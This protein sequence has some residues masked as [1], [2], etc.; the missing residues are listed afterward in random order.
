M[1]RPTNAARAEAQ[2]LQREEAMA[3]VTSFGRP[4]PELTPGENTIPYG[5]TTDEMLRERDVAA[6]VESY[7]TSAAAIL[8]EQARV[9]GKDVATWRK[10]VEADPSVAEQLYMQAAQTRAE[11]V[12]EDHFYY[13]KEREIGEIANIVN[14]MT[15]DQQKRFSQ[16]LVPEDKRNTHMALWDPPM[17]DGKVYGFSLIPNGLVRKKLDSGWGIVPK[18]AVAEAPSLQC[19]MTDDTG[20]QC[21]KK[22]RTEGQ[23][24]RHRV[25][26][27][28]TAYKDREKLDAQ[29][30]ADAREQADAQ[31][32]DRMEQLVEQQA[33]MIAAL[34]QRLGG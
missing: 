28:N 29:R 7:H 12:R 4:I 25:V 26:K 31:R 27:H 16:T 2:R 5:I 17:R 18:G 13:G 15:V 33:Q 3:A 21:P 19:D 23:V 20:V 22:F 9:V 24:E 11:A 32:A 1:P 8:E 34:T 10:L 30:K 6:M 14:G